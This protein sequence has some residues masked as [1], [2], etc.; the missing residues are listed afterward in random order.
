M[1]NPQGQSIPFLNQHK[2]IT[3]GNQVIKKRVLTICTLLLCSGVAYAESESENLLL[4]KEAAASTLFSA[5]EVWNAAYGYNDGWRTTQH[6]RMIADVNGDGLKDI[7]G[8]GKE[9][10]YVSLSSGT[11]FAAPA[12][13]VK[14]YTPMYGWQVPLH[15]R[16]MADANGDGLADIIGFGKE[17]VYVSLSTGSEF[18]TPKLWVQQFGYNQGWRKLRHPRQVADVNG[19]GMVD[20]IGFADGG[21]IVALSTG[22]GFSAPSTW[23]EQYGFNQGWRINK[24]PGQWLM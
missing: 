8:F 17:G 20:I 24:H 4:E 7:V 1:V 2:K 23:V 13:W 14:N 19:D 3:Q 5:A 6:P 10:V 9:G 21:V 12:L 18:S 22:N 11:E 16:V 15:P